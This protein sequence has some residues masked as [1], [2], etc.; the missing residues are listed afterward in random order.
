MPSTYE[1]NGIA[2]T[3]DTNACSYC[4]QIAGSNAVSV[5][6]E[7]LRDRRPDFLAVCIDSPDHPGHDKG[8][9]SP[10]YY[11]KVAELDRG[12]AEIVRTLEQTGMADESVLIVSSDHGGKNKKHGGATLEEME[13]PVFIWG[14][15][16]KRGHR[17]SFGGTIYDTGA[18]IAELLG[19]TPPRAWIGRPFDEAFESD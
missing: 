19:V 2:A 16:V 15:N 12:L 4:R 3:V 9:G 1:W 5:A 10:E 11:D 14:K 18:T 6:C 13:R 8:W 7:Y 17:L